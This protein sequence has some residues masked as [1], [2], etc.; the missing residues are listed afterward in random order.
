MKFSSQNWGNRIR[1]LEEHPK[2]LPKFKRCRRQF[3]AWRLNTHH[4][5]SEKYK[6]EEE[7]R[8][9]C[10]TLQCCFEA[11]MVS[12]QINAETLPPPKDFPYLGQAID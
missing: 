8:L 2:P 10:E 6:Q 1:I 12:F 11:G 5:A 9:I 7:R 4:Y 3:P